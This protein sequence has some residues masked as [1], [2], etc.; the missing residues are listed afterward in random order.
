MPALFSSLVDTGTENEL[1]VT[2]TPVAIFAMS[3]AAS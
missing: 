3:P 2:V 1:S